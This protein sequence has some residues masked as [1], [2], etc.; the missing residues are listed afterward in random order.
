MNF[1]CLNTIS[2][3][4]HVLFEKEPNPTFS[5]CDRVDC[6][7]KGQTQYKSAAVLTADKT[8]VDQTCKF[9]KPETLNGKEI[10]FL[11]ADQN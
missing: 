7:M 4:V 5:S 6:T 10:V 8:S 3:D 9:S 2:N 11:Q 1:I